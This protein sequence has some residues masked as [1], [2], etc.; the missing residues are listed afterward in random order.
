MLER[1]GRRELR[2]KKIGSAYAVAEL[3]ARPGISHF[4]IFHLQLQL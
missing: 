2:I 4:R 1:D 3:E